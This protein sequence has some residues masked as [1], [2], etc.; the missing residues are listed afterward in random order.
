MGSLGIDT[1][2]YRTSVAYAD[3]QGYAQRRQLL[4][5]PLGK[6]GLM[7]SELVFQ[8]IQNL[9]QL[10]E[11]LIQPGMRIDCVCASARPRPIEGSYMPVFTVGE[12]TARSIAKALSAPLFRT[13]HQ[14][15]H[16]RAALHSA[17]PGG[18]RFLAVHLSGGTTE[19]L[20]TNRSLEVD[21][22]GGT[23]DLNAGQLVDRVGVALGCAFPAG[24]ELEALAESYAPKSLIPVAINGLSCS[25]SGAEAQAL[26]LIESGECEKGQLAAEVYSVLTRTLARLLETASERTG[27][28][29]AL[30]FGGVASSA[31]LRKMLEERLDRRGIH[32]RLHWAS[33]ELSGDNAVGAAL[34]GLEHLQEECTL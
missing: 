20:L 29:E 33:P 26:R 22:L 18:A 30:L 23:S 14:Q 11:S 1:S 25:F 15:C 19:L 10:L 16:L 31:L 7:Q 27:V 8:H 21:L 24:P 17:M 28:R 6:R 4:E 13:S 12:G 3:D 34:I 5:V 2:C 32:V 9:P